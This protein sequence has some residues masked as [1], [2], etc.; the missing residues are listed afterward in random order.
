[1]AE[2]VRRFIPRAPRYIL[3]P[4]DSHLLYFS[5]EEEKGVKHP[6]RIFN[7]SESGIAF[8]VPSALAPRISD[9]LK[10][11][12]QVPAG[13]NVAWWGRVVRL[14]ENA[15]PWWWHEEKAFNEVLVGLHFDNLPEPHRQEIHEGLR[16]R[17]HKLL[18]ERR[19][20]QVNFVRTWLF[21]HI[22]QLLLFFIC[23]TAL[24]TA[25]YFIS[26]VEP[27]FDIKEGSIYL[28]L[29]EGLDF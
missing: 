2:R 23:A 17:H 16:A 10:V 5:W 14:Q 11:E 3:G 20:R 25:L 13:L 29:W 18:L 19:R 1:M 4:A 21:D 12:F 6:T 28:K 15:Y 9:R 22:R 26:K 8:F 7:V 24:I 27:F